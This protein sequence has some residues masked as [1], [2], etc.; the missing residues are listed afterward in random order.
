MTLHLTHIKP[1]A[2]SLRRSPHATVVTLLTT[3]FGTHPRQPVI[4]AVGGPGGT[5]KTTQCTNLA[6]LIPGAAVLSLDEHKTPRRELQRLN[7]AE[8]PKRLP[9]SN[10][11]P[12]EEGQMPLLRFFPQHPLRSPHRE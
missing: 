10:G 3:L 2:G 9:A 8:Y 6:P 7:A 1:R 5:G 11:L 4:I 12:H